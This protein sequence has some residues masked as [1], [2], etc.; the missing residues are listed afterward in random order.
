[1]FI[2]YLI[3]IT[4]DSTTANTIYTKVFCFHGQNTVPLNFN[5]PL[6]IYWVTYSVFLSTKQKK[7]NI[8]IYIYIY[9]YV[10]IK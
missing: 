8:N 1:M 3:K 7:L 9:M 5:L 2:L 10:N 4:T 6:Y